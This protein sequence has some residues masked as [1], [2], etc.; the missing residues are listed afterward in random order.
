MILMN[1]SAVLLQEKSGA[2]HSQGLKGLV[3]GKSQH[4]DL[5][6]DIQTR[7]NCLTTFTEGAN[8]LRPGGR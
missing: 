4:G 6:K 7:T 5:F 1:D 2:N 3:I 8:P